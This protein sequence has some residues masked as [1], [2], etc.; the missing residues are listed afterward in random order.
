MI[1]LVY[2]A[3]EYGA[4][5]MTYKEAFLAAGDSM[6][7]TGGLDSAESF[8]VWFAEWNKKLCE[9]TVPAG[10]V[11][12]TTYLAVDECDTLV[13]MIDIRHRLNDWLLQFG[14]HIGYSVAPAH[15][16]KGYAKEMLRLALDQCRELGIEQALVT[17]YDDH[18][19][20]AKTIEHNGGILE[21]KVLEGEKVIRRYWIT[22]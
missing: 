22:L 11:P 21:N 9:E 19:A 1:R 16:R 8:E 12:A 10:L 2:P 5:I 3:P 18:I 6:D 7:G 15:R 14:G 17:C 4:Q 20:S 13:G